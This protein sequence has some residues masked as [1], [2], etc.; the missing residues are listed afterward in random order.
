MNSEIL[1]KEWF[2]KWEKGNYF[3][4][5]I[6]ENFRHISPFGTINGK[7]AYLDLVKKNE[8]KFLNQTFEIH[9]GIYEDDRACVRYTTKQGNDFTLDVSEWYYFKDHLIKKVIA[10]YHIGKI[11]DERKLQE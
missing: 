1:V 6:S 9:D 2:D 11:R 8:D 3:D 7:Q 5:P 10:Y 4:L